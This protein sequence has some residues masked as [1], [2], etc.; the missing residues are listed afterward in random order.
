MD[1]PIY[2]Q[3]RRKLD[4]PTLDHDLI[5]ITEVAVT[6][7]KD[8]PEFDLVIGVELS[9]YCYLEGY[10]ERGRRLPPV[11]P[12]SQGEGRR[13]RCNGYVVD[14]CNWRRIDELV[15]PARRQGSIS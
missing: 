15:E 11:N 13:G 2:L 5:E 10:P 14:D 12:D 1:N 3:S 9:R 4:R 7:L 8:Y 6:K